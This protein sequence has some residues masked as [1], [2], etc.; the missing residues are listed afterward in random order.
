M[1]QSPGLKDAQ[2]RVQA[3]REQ[4][5]YHNHR[6]YV[7]DDPLLPDAEYDRLLQQLAALER[8]FPQLLTADSPTQRVGAQPLKEF[9]EIRH[10]LP[11]LSLDNAFTEQDVSDFDRRV[12]ERLGLTADDEQVE[13]AAEPKLDGLAVSLLYEGG[14]LL[15]GATRGDGSIGE[16]ITQNVRTIGCIPLRLRG[17]TFPAVLEVRGEVYMTRE[18]FARLNQQQQQHGDKLFANPRNA[19]A[20][21]LRQL[22]PQVTASRP[23][24]FCSYG[25]GVVEGKYLPT[26]H[27]DWLGAL[28]SWGLRV[29]EQAQVV[30]GVRGCLQFYHALG[31]ARDGLAYQ[32]DGAVYK[33]NEL[34]LQQQLGF[35]AR[36]PRWAIAHKYPAQEELTEVLDIEWQVGRTGTL[37]PVARLAPVSVGG[38]TVSNATLHNIDEVLRKDVRVGDTVIVRRAGDVIPEVVSVIKERRPAKVLSVKLPVVCPVCG[39]EVLRVDGESAIRCNAGLFCPAQRKEAI[40]HF[41]SRRALDIEGLGEKLIDQLVD[42][43]LVQHVDDLYQL[44]IEQLAV[45]QRMGEKSAQNLIEALGHS[46]QTT[47]AR[48]LYSLGIR[49]VGE[50]TARTLAEHFGTLQAIIEASEDELLQ[51]PDIGPVSASYIAAF[52]A[53]PHNRQVISKLRK[54]GVS[55]P[56]EASAPRASLPLSGKTFVLTGTLQSLTRDQARERLQALGAKVAG[57]VSAKTD[58]VVAGSDAGTKLAKA[59]QLGIAVLDEAGLLSMLDNAAAHP[60]Q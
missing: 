32:I 44:D 40:R 47:L 56:E 42:E 30:H 49:E 21:S 29:S 60:P 41:A 2:Q 7:L 31:A 27:S 12:R 52:F 59:Q 26:R 11:M 3:L 57:S 20:G 13:Y 45:L 18:G 46:K 53:E 33:V 43:G 28:R 16:D 17:N 37:T 14:R 25:V 22:D 8:Q 48:F 55:W 23:L 19:A 58:Y 54:A 5:D 50:A 34:A 4:I 1:T 39:S 15:R 9:G 51:V 10:Q 35:V 24:M 36:A 38:V 6:Y